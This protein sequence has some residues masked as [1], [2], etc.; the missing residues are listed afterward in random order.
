MRCGVIH[1][2]LYVHFPAWLGS[3]FY[4]EL[5]YEER[6]NEGKWSKPGRGANEAFDLLYADALAILSGYEKIKWPSAP[7]WARRETWI[8][9][10]QTETG[11]A[12]SPIPARNQSQNQNVRSP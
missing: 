5:T 1:P 12:P 4:D 2:G 6:S 3:W 10:T 8:E 7:E 11:E 9:S